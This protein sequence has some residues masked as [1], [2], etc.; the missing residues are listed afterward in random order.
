MFEQNLTAKRKDS[1]FTADM[2]PL[3]A[4]GRA[5]DFEDA[6]ERVWYELIARL[7]G[8]AWKGD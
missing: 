2:T 1:L 5:W 7:P 6:F 4:H 8:A 3:L